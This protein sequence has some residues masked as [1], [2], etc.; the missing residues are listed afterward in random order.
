M[1][2]GLNHI[3]LAV[4]DLGISLG[5]YTSIGFKLRARWNKGAYLEVGD[6]WVCLTLDP[7]T[8]PRDDYTH[9]AFSTTLKGM[10]QLEE[11]IS[12][13]S[14]WHENKSEGASLYFTD[15]NGHKLEAHVGDLGSRLASLLE[16]PYEGSVLYDVE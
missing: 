6:T 14:R 9:L 3:T 13:E 4:K 11:V 2:T 10:R 12:A 1:L 5:F 15:P 7:S 16:A 8:T